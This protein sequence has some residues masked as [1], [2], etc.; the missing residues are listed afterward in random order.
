[1]A[2]G[3]QQHDVLRLVVRRGIVLALVGAVSGIAIALGVTRY[4]ASLLYGIRPADPVTFIVIAI[5]LVA[6]ALVACFIPARRATRVDPITALRN[7]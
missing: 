4:L 5:L 1:M 3:A 7:E 2:L 6:V